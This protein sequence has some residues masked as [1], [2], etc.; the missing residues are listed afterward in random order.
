MGICR[1]LTGLALALTCKASYMMLFDWMYPFFTSLR[2]VF[3]NK[4]SFNGDSH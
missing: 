1:D 3:S 4:L 2:V